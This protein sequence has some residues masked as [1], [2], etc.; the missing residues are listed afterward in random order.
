MTGS[1]LTL[2]PQPTQPLP[3]RSTSVA[4]P[5]VDEVE[6]RARRAHVDDLP[7]L[8]ALWQRV[9]LPWDQLERFLTEFIVVMDSEGAILAAV[10]LQTAG[11]EGL[12]HSE[13]VIPRDDEAELRSALWQR[14]QI[15]ARNQGVGR[16]WTLEDDAFWRSIFIPASTADIA[17]SPLASADLQAAWSTLQL[18][19][20]ARAQKLIDERMALWEASRQSD[21]TGLHDTITQIRRFAFALAGGVIFMMVLMILYVLIRKPGAFNT[22]LQHVR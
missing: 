10:G 7:G 5:A 11:E 18:V 6:Y 8:E 12:V 4:S 17:A 14:L 20:R 21:S 22:L 13:A 3:L 16:L 2:F 1:D 9:G 19:D 15:V